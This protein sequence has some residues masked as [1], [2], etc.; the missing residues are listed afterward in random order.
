MSIVTYVD[1]CID[2]SS[3]AAFSPEGSKQVHLEGCE[4]KQ[5]LKS[6]NEIP[7]FFTQLYIYNV[8]STY[9]F[10]N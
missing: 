2:V 7:N 1:K 4:Y 6:L 5:P 9:F 10:F 8:Y 3:W